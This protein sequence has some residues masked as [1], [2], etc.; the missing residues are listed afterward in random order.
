MGAVE[1]YFKG[2]EGEEE[3]IFKSQNQVKIGIFTFKMFSISNSLFNHL[4]ICFD[5]I[6]LTN[7]HNFLC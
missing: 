4:T 1:I 6:H 2:N 3:E 5:K 7:W